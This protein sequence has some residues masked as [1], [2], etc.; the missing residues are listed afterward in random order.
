MIWTIY[1]CQLSLHVMGNSMH[2]STLAWPIMIRKGKQ[3]LHKVKYK[4]HK[5][6]SFQEVIYNSSSILQTNLKT[7]FFTQFHMLLSTDIYSFCSLTLFGIIKLFSYKVLC[8]PLITSKLSFFALPK[9]KGEIHVSCEVLTCRWCFC[10]TARPWTFNHKGQI[11]LYF[12]KIVRTLHIL[13]YRE[14]NKRLQPRPNVRPYCPSEQDYTVIG[15][16]Y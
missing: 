7:S 2:R 1:Y 9:Q 6:S 8:T 14:G 4:F 10:K 3:V 5:F 11:W 16:K 15:Q 12:Q 13:H